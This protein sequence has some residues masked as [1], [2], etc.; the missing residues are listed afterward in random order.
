MGKKCGPSRSVCGMITVP[1]GDAVSETLPVPGCESGIYREWYR[2]K[3]ASSELQFCGH[4]RFVKER[5]QWRSARLV[6][7]DQKVMVTQINHI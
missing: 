3:N 5:G 4:K 1:D 7:A 2:N 6:P